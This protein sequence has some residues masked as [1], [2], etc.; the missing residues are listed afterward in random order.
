MSSKTGDVL[1]CKECG[2][3]V[4]VNKACGCGDKECA[5]TCCDKPMEK[6][7]RTGCC[8]CG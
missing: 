2:L 8:C 6:K 3:E 1:V 7:Q 4:T 5:V